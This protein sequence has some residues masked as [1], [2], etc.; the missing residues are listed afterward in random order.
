MCPKRSL[1]LVAVLC[2]GPVAA[3]AEPGHGL[4][5]PWPGRAGLT[6]QS[7]TPELR[8]HFGAPEDSGVL[9]TRVREDGP[10]AEAG[11][12]V[13]DVVVEADGKPVAKPRELVRRVARAPEGATLEL[14]LVRAGETKQ[15]RVALEGEPGRA[16]FAEDWESMRERFQRWLP[17][18]LG[19]LEELERRLR[20][21]ER[22]VREAL[23]SGTHG[24][25]TRT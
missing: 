22:R 21:L 3:S 18:D 5:E 1:V 20:E 19:R 13:G 10:A 16:W 4:H 15:V 24:D 12:R 8:V 14:S 25:A 9:V 6:I 17:P 7:M 23:E 11:V 2:L